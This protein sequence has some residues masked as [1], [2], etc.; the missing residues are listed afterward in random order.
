MQIRLHLLLGLQK[1]ACLKIEIKCSSVS[2]LNITLGLYSVMNML[3]RFHSLRCSITYLMGKWAA[4]YAGVLSYQS[5]APRK[6]LSYDTLRD[7][8]IKKMDE[9]DEK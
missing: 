6:E 1:D 8:L 7:I 2:S 9:Q 5:G 4:Y 3:T